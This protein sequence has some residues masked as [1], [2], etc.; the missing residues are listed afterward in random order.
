MYSQFKSITLIALTMSLF[1]LSAC[2]SLGILNLSISSKA[3]QL[4]P[5]IEYQAGIAQTLDVY[6]PINTAKNSSCENCPVVIW[7]YGGAWE[8]GQKRDY[9]FIGEAFTAADMV[10]V[11][12]DY[13][14]FPEVYFPDFIEDAAHA[15]KWTHDNINSF[16]GNPQN[17]NIIGHSAGAHIAMMLA[18]DAH[19]LQGVGLN[20]TDINT[21]IGLAGPYN[22]LPFTEPNVA[23][24][25]STAQPT[26]TSQP[27]FYADNHGP[28][29]LLTVGMKDKRVNPLNS[30]SFA[31]ELKHEGGQV[32]L[33][34]YP[35]LNHA[36][37]LLA[38]AKPFRRFSTAYS[39]LL[40]F[41]RQAH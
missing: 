38:L 14:Q 13:R 25:F 18:F 34:Q 19:Y 11:I 10:V 17:L 32:Q 41:I 39:D 16:G 2:S 4:T 30:M 37:L 28:K 33:I 12:P 27:I 1:N 9:A 20:R 29:T 6:Q 40:L 22:F 26:E 15:V 23:E 5:N 21:A 31:K 7:L 36:S 35:K 24:L 8:S 3:Y